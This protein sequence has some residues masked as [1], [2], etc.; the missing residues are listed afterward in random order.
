MMRA[1][2]PL[3][4]PI[5]M[6][7]ACGLLALSLAPVVWADPP[8][9]TVAAP[10]DRAAP[11]ATPGVDAVVARLDEEARAPAVDVRLAPSANGVLGAWLVAGPFKASRPALD[12]APA[13][14]DEKKLV[15]ALN[16][17]LGGPRDLGGG[18]VRPPARWTLVSSGPPKSGAGQDPGSQ[19]SRT[20]DLKASLD[21]AAGTELVAYAAGRLHVETAGRYYLALGVDDGVRVSVDGAVVFSRD[22]ARPVRD[23]DDVVPLDLA[24]GDHDV[25]LKLHQQSGAWAFRARLVDEALAPPRSAWLA[26]PGTT[27]DDARALAARMSWLVVD[28]AFDAGATPPRYRPVLTVRYPEGAPRGV[29]IEVSAK[30]GGVPEASAFDV[31]AGGVAVTSAGV[32]DL[33]VTLPAIEPW[34]GTATLESSV[35]GRVVTS[36]LVARPRSERALT[37]AVRALERLKGDE[38]WLEDGS[39][40][41]VRHLTRRLA[42]LVARGD[43]DGEAQSEEARELDELAANLE[44][45]VDPYAGR[46]G[47][48]RRA[49]VTPLDGGPSEFGLYV[50]PSY[51]PGGTRKY[52]LVV[53]LHGLNSYPMSM[54]RALFGLDDDKKPSAW[55]DRHAV[56]LPAA[57]VDAFVITPYAHGNTMYREI[58]EDDV[59]YLTRWAAK[60]FPIDE[61]RITVTGPSMGGIGSAGIPLHYPHVFAAAAPLCGYHS[62]LIRPDIASRP[63]R[64]WE[65]S[66]LEQ[67]SNV[68]WAE[69]GEHLPLWIVHGTR[70]LPEANS[71]VL[72]ERYEKLKYSI[73][74]DHPE[75]GHNVW[76][77]TYGE[78]KGLRWLLSQRLDPHPARVRFRT[79]RTRYA[80]SA[81][82]TVD[83]L[84]TPHGWGDVDARVKSPTAIAL[85]TSGVSALTLTRDDKLIDPRAPVAVTADGAT[86]SFGEGEALALHKGPGGGWEKGAAVHARPWKSGRVS[87]PIRDAFH[88]PLLFVYGAGDDARAN[89]LVARGFAERPGVTA[90]YPVMSDAEFL[91]TGQPLAN[92]RALFLVGR[93]NRVLAALDSAAT[94]AGAPFPLRVESGKVTLGKERFTGSEL[95]GAF[96][97]PNP[98]RPDRYVVVVAGADPIGTLRALS[99]PDL[100]PDFVVWDGGL[101]PARGQLLLGAGALRAG[102]SFENDWSLPAVTADPLAKSAR[103]STESE[104]DAPPGS[105]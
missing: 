48:M 20:I 19:G 86:L 57:T 75:A 70:D 38:P 89:E 28:R 85:T 17:A 95:G 23:D 35:A 51:K 40:D 76:G 49:L 22:D 71:G 26:L 1:S 77:I 87:G 88:E 44:R 27:A 50:P 83:E 32:A 73:R 64:P 37:R 31:R 63:K 46:S 55:K 91:A 12:A 103:P 7:S 41:S 102:G 33:V 72:I 100:L 6:G 78:L 14:V 93:A 4:L 21:D 61:T 82:V 34:T 80:T 67:R 59:L 92:D 97:H 101:A 58:G 24:A 47:M 60:R 42:R 99:L 43:G 69:N 3:A 29:P 54:M 66:L 9:A 65:R 45:A 68:F 74:H 84:A 62:Y 39:L 25:V 96:I 8:A 53:G 5:A 56:P 105:P 13:G 2:I 94:N 15:P 79:M 36:T 81:W 90:S 10:A 30:L 11:R 104:R 18:K 16:V 52:P 98:V